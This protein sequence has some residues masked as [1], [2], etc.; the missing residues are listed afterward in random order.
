[1]DLA[2]TIIFLLVLNLVIG[3]LLAIDHRTAVHGLKQPKEQPSRSEIFSLGAIRMGS[4]GR[5]TNPS[6]DKAL[7]RKTTALAGSGEAFAQCLLGKIHQNGTGVIP[8]MQQAMYWY[9]RAALQGH[10]EAQYLLACCRMKQGS[11]STGKHEIEYLLRLS[12]AG[13]WAQAQVEL[14]QLLL[15]P[16]R[17][18]EDKVEARKWMQRAAQQGHFKPRKNHGKSYSGLQLH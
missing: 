8:N 17:R 16:G 15:A 4:S 10:S 18:A 2:L 9:E 7:V 11:G 6:V 12:A 13:G 1:M 5:I 14:A 3:I